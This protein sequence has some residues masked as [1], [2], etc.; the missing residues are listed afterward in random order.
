MR[1]AG[2]GGGGDEAN[3]GLVLLYHVESMMA[4]KSIERR[5]KPVRPKRKKVTEAKRATRQRMRVARMTVV[6]S[7]HS[8]QIK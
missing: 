7:T 5:P 8:T 2:N 3:W 4:R 6:E 1:R